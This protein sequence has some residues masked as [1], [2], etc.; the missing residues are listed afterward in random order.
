MRCQ[1][2]NLDSQKR[3]SIKSSL[4]VFDIFAAP[5]NAIEALFFTAFEVEI[6]VDI[7]SA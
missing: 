6:A 5:R 1:S 4:P 2:V 3:T 7:V